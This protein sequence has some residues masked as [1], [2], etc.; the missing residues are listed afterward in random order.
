MFITRYKHYHEAVKSG[1]DLHTQSKIHFNSTNPPT[2]WCHPA[3]SSPQIL[4]P[5]F[6]CMFHFFH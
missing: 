4:A 6:T 3:V 5:N 1:L 2:S